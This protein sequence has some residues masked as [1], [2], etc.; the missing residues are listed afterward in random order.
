MSGWNERV[1]GAL[2]RTAAALESLLEVLEGVVSTDKER[3]RSLSP[4]ESAT[5]TTP[6]PTTTTTAE[7]TTT[8]S[9]GGD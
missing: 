4:A 9:N 8:T 3:V 2:N 7:P 1:V 6:E 5:T